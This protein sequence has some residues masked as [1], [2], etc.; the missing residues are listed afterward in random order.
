MKGYYRVRF[1]NA[2]DNVEHVLTLPSFRIVY[3]DIVDDNGK[4]VAYY[5]S[6]F[7]GWCVLDP[8]DADPTPP[9][10]LLGRFRAFQ[11]NWVEI[12]C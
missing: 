11:V 10:N 1:Y 5:N 8:N 7:G 4:V 12:Q 2:T 3:S 9:R 6:I